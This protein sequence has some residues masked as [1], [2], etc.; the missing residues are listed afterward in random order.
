MKRFIVSVVVVTGLIAVVGCKPQPLTIDTEAVRAD[1]VKKGWIPS[2]LP[3]GSTILRD[4]DTDGCTITSPKLPRG[5]EANFM[6]EGAAAWRITSKP[7]APIVI[8]CER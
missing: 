8:A 4:P 7:P 1:F 3:L 6:R 2:T 5:F